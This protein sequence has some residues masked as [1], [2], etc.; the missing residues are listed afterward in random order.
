MPIAKPWVKVDG[1]PR[2]YVTA[3][4]L[5]PSI[6]LPWQRDE[7][8]ADTQ[9]GVLDRREEREKRERQESVGGGE[10]DERVERLMSN[11]RRSRVVGA[12]A[13]GLL[14]TAQSLGVGEGG[15]GFGEGLLKGCKAASCS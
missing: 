9:E 5:T 14:G 2:P 11:G 8:C 13:K 15:G 3:R 12:E 6:F 10:T 7:G 4:I 1:H